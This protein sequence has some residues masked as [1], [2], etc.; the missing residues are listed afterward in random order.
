[1]EN[2]GPVTNTSIAIFRASA[3]GSDLNNDGIPDNWFIQ[4]GLAPTNSADTVLPSGATYRDIYFHDI[5]PTSPLPPNFN[6]ALANEMMTGNVLRLV[7]EPTSTGRIYDVFWTT[8]L[9]GGWTDYGFNRPGNG[10]LLIL[11]ITNE[12]ELRYYRT[13]VKI[14]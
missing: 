8:N 10:G 7:I 9:L 3:A 6:R 13:G 1:V 14:P 11:S 2:P 5:N 12:A 4:N